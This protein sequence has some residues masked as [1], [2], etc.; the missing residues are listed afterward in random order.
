MTRLARGP[1]AVRVSFVAGPQPAPL[2]EGTPLRSDLRSR[3]SVAYD[4]SR[5]KRPN[6]PFLR[7]VI[8]PG[9][10]EARRFG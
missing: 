9:S 8:A 10:I 6:G 5:V 7:L 3:R 4:P 1:T 2:E